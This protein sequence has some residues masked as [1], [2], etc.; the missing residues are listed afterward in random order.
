MITEPVGERYVDLLQAF[1]EHHILGGRFL[2]TLG[3]IKSTTRITGYREIDEST[4]RQHG[5]IIGID[6]VRS[7]LRTVGSDSS[8]TQ[9]LMVAPYT[10][11]SI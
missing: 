8:L 4:G 7:D 11:S 1:D 9:E 3:R 6:P 10:V 2:A 5:D